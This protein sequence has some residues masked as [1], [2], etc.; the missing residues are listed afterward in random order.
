MGA[1]VGERALR[2][3]FSGLAGRLLVLVDQINEGLDQIVV[4]LAKPVVGKTQQVQ[5]RDGDRHALQLVHR[6]ELH[7]R[8]VIPAA[9]RGNSGGLEKVP[10]ELMHRREEFPTL[11]FLTKFLV[12][13][14][15]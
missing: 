5:A 9:F 7:E 4:D 14:V 6:V 8:R 12:A 3:L 11:R 10:G 2:G 15:F 1:G 13:E